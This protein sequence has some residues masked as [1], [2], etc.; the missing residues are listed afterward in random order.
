MDMDALG[1]FF[2]MDEIEKQQQ[3]DSDDSGNDESN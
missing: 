2:Y 3:E 1:Y